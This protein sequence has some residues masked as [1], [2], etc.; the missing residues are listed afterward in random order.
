MSY[1]VDFLPVGNGEKSGDAIAVRFGDLLSGDRSKQ[2]VMVIDGG[3]KESGEK[4]VNHIETYYKTTHV[5]LV[6]NTHPDGDHASGLSVVLEELTVDQLW[7]H[8]PWEHS[9]DIHHMFHDGRITPGSLSERMRA[10]LQNAKDLEAIAKRKGIPIVEPFAGEGGTALGCTVR[11]LGPDME[12][13]QSLLP[14]FRSTPEKR[15]AASFAEMMMKAAFNAAGGVA[16][17]AQRVMESFGIE[18]LEDPEDDATSAENNSSAIIC[19]Q[20]GDKQLLFTG[21]AGVPALER[22][23]DWATWNGIVLSN[24]NFH[25]VPHH[26]S[27]RNIGP[28]ILDRILGPKRHTDA[29]DKVAF[30]SASKDAPKHPSRRVTNAYRRRGAKVI[31]TEGTAIWHSSGDVPVRSNYS[32]APVVPF[33]S[34]VEED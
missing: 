31:T 13:Y 9:Q 23:N 11:V 12:Y 18:T 15:Q 5:D 19:L 7:M 32:A 21:D 10:A 22:A 28:S 1:E 14:D 20:I 29:P 4:L 16:T 34:E 2:F 33:Y 8:L 6:V 27:R 30:V 24:C 25:Q 3:T 17:M 26:G